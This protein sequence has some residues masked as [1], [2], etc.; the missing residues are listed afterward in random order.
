MDSASDWRPSRNVGV[1]WSG[2]HI[3][4]RRW[5]S[6]RF[7]GSCFSVEI[8]RKGGKM[9]PFGFC[10]SLYRYVIKIRDWL[11]SQNLDEFRQ[12]PFSKTM[13]SL[14]FNDFLYK[15]DCI[16]NVFGVIDEWRVF[17]NFIKK[18]WVRG[19]FQRIHQKLS[20]VAGLYRIESPARRSQVIKDRNMLFSLMRQHKGQIIVDL[21]WVKEAK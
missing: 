3:W 6:W 19:T 2:L 17:P 12:A 18:I 5:L 16:I 7:F 8:R 4:S 15:C 21:C 1:P 9:D 14:K 11:G 13:I 10:R 20:E